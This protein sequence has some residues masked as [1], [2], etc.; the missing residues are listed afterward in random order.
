MLYCCLILQY[1][2]CDKPDTFEFHDGTESELVTPEGLTFIALIA[3][4][5]CQPYL[6][7]PG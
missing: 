5:N 3:D 4:D 1:V 7:G 6:Y 2:P